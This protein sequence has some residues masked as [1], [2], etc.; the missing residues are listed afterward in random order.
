M[1]D[2]Y[3]VFMPKMISFSVRQNYTSRE[4]LK[5]SEVGVGGLGNIGQH[6]FG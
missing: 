4:R 5:M 2:K 3:G 6:C 1:I